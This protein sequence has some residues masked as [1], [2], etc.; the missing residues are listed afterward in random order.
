MLP[1]HRF[2]YLHNFQRALDWIGERYADLLD[3]REQGF[4]TGFSALPQQSQALLVRMLMRRGP[5]FRADKLVYEEIP[6]IAAAAGPLLAQGWIDA[7]AAMALDE[8]FALHTKP[9]LRRIF[10]EIPVR[11]DIRK[12]ELFKILLALHEAPRTYAD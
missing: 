7:D 5:W 10:A 8:L 4:L 12:P 9:E 6:D 3:V 11:A 2:Y 1:P